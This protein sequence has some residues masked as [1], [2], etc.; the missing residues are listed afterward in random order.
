MES[1]EINIDKLID[2][3]NYPV[4]IKD[5]KDRLNTLEAR[6]LELLKAANK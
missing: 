3:L 5:L 2:K 6:L 1:I 4:N